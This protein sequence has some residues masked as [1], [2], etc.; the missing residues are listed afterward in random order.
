MDPA[1]IS[2]VSVHH[3]NFISFC[4][5]DE[6]ERIHESLSSQPRW[7]TQQTCPQS[8]TE[9]MVRS[10]WRSAF[11]ILELKR[12]CSLTCRSQRWKCELY[13]PNPSMHRSDDHTGDENKPSCSTCS[14]LQRV[15][16]WGIKASFHDSRMCFLS[17]KD[18]KQLLEIEDEVYRHH[19][20]RVLVCHPCSFAR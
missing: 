15:C 3:L 18:A 5:F 9:G 1:A 11:M 8:I 19:S 10:S 14:R 4:N 7:S 17:A 16:R 13:M 6:N 12:P 20:S 2:H